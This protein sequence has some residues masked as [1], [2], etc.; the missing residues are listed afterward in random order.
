MVLEGWAAAGKGTLVKKM[1]NYMDPRG[2]TVHPILTPSPQEES[3]PFLW[4]FWQKLPAKGSIGI[5][6]HSWYTH[7]LEDRLLNKLPSS[8]IPLVMR[9]INTFERQLFDDGIAIAKFWIHL[10]QKELKS[11]IK[12]YA[13]N[14]LESW[15][16]RPED[17]QQGGDKPKEV[18]INERTPDKI[19][20]LKSLIKKS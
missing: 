7:L 19:I 14:E 3:Y 11:R 10:S 2:F 20:R 17:W 15:R 4:R 8:Q 12:E 9:D 18:P 6:Y 1:V 5:F 16:V 13:E